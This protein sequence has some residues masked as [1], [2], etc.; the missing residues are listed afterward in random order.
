MDFESSNAGS[1]QSK[2]PL[3][4]NTKNV[5]PMELYDQALPA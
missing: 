1:L 3:L 4:K 5:D 2:G